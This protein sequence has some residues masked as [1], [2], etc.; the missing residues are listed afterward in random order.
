MFYY[1]FSKTIFLCRDTLI[2]IPHIKSVAINELP[3]I[4]INGSGI[5]FVGNIPMVTEIFIKAWA[6][7]K[8]VKPITSR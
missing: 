8:K 5:P 4:E 3:P 1:S 7:I 6:T 2:I